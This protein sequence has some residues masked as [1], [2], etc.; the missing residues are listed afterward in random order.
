MKI[1]SLL[2]LLAVVP[3]AGCSGLGQ[4]SPAAL[5]TVV[6]GSNNSAA[7]TASSRPS[8]SVASG[9]VT[10]SGNVAPA[11]E[12]HLSFSLSGRVK[13]V[14]VA[15]GD[16]V[17][18]G[19]VLVTL[20]DALLQ[21]QIQQ[22]E[23]GVAAAQANYELLAAGPTNEQL[24]QAEAALAG[25]TAAYNRTVEGSRPSDIAAAAAALT[26]AT[27]A[28]NKV[29]AGPQPL[30]YAAAEAA[31]K[32]AQAARQQAQFAYDAA[33]QSNPAAIGASPAALALQQATNNYASAKAA[34]DQAV[35]GP[36]AATLSAA[37]LQVQSARAALDAAM[38]P[39]RDADIAQA[40]AQVAQ[41]QAQLDAL[42]A[43]PRAQQLDAARAQVDAAKAALVVLQ[44]QVPQYVLTAPLD[45]VVLSRAIQPGETA[46]PGA[47]VMALGTLNHLRVET[48]DLS[49]RD[50]PRVQVDQPVSVYIK[51]L[52]KTV[53]GKV[54]EIAPLADTLGGDVVYKTTIELDTQPAGLRAGMSVDVLFG[55]T[56]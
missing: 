31:V 29:K 37:Y 45:G 13:T 54:R 3:L 20:D 48:T 23:A 24:R 30:D 2:I 46:V 1:E 27:D 44:A 34:Y 9:G 50:V 38:H 18:A 47:P 52:D 32:N 15:A 36:D 33:Y 12:V 39:A 35:R 43:G 4:A 21:A 5:P 41:A 28:Y 10:A 14:S 25:A 7:P 53:A 8:S 40:K 16:A 11:Q 26:A 19:Q 49:E 56:R 51:A 42:K 22:A 17:K 55:A 6:L